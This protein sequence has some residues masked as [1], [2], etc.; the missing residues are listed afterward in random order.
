MQRLACVYI[1]IRHMYLTD[2]LFDI[3]INVCARINTSHVKAK[4]V[5]A[6][7]HTKK[8]SPKSFVI[9]GRIFYNQLYIS[10][11][12]NVCLA[13]IFVSAYHNKGDESLVKIHPV[14]SSGLSTSAME[15]MVV[16]GIICGYIAIV[17]AG[18]GNVLLF[19]H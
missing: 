15:Y 1:S 13:H 5:S 19:M 2:R 4:S 3:V 7:C 10:L 11:Y 6:R 14:N 18:D 9:L 17:L 8:T 16:L 12:T